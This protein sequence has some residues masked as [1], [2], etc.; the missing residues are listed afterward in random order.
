MRHENTLDAAE[1]ALVIIDMQEGFRS[2]MPDFAEVSVRIALMAHAAQLLGLPVLVTEQYPKG[3]GQTA[4]EIRAVLPAAFRFIE[5]TAFSSCG[6]QTFVGELERVRARHVLVCGIEAH[7]CVNQTTHDLLARN[8]QV[9]LLTECITSRA[10]HNR[11]TG[12]AK[13]QQSGAFPSSIEMALFELMRDAAH[14]QFKAVQKL[15]K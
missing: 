9:H 14:E 7:V 8:Y 4:G 11:E 2:A 1:T 13:M 6:A 5:K 15:I 12:L 10:P 3:L